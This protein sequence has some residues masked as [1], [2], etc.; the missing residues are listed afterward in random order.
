MATNDQDSNRD[1]PSGGQSPEDRLEKIKQ[2]EKE[3]ASSFY[4]QG[5]K[6]EEGNAAD[7]FEKPVPP[8]DPE[9]EEMSL[10]K[11]VAF[12]GFGMAALAI[13]F[14]LFFIRDLGNKVGDV[15]AAVHTLEQK[16]GPLRQE[17]DE[18][19][20]K[21]NADVTD[22]KTRFGTYERQV[23]V[24]ELKRALVSIQG[25]TGNAP[26]DVQNKSG[27]VVASIESLLQELEGN[28]TGA[29][30]APMTNSAPQ[31]ET[32]PA[33]AVEETTESGSA[34][35]TVAASE[36][37]APVGQIELESESS[38]ESSDDSEE[39]ASEEGGE[40]EDEDEFAEDE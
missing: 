37:T 18:Q 35:E 9:K 32:A 15:D 22:L 33:P 7:D 24:T 2:E 14:I 38:E 27:Q 40:E 12:L 36:E 29:P 16:F 4:A 3:D 10:L 23:V 30:M 17:V 31:P 8:V 26:A 19:L 21:V 11:A 20:S 25:I 6:E 34:E 39:E 28:N 1:N 5:D 13:I